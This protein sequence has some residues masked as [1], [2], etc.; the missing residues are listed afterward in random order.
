M[1]EDADDGLDPTPP[2][3]RLVFE[4][5]PESADAD[6]KDKDNSNGAGLARS[7]DD[8]D[9]ECCESDADEAEP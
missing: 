6:G 1:P 4:P 8:E 9:V 3:L 5:A 7:N 2:A